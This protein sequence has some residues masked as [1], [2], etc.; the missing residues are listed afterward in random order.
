MKTHEKILS[1]DL[2]RKTFGNGEF[3]G[4]CD[5]KNIGAVL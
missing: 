2:H 3:V 4:F 5:V 1:E